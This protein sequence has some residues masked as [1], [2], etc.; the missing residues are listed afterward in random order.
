MPVGKTMGPQTKIT[1]AKGAGSMANAIHCLCGKHE[2]KQ[3]PS[4][5]SSTAETNK[6]QK[7]TTL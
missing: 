2:F 7:H 3:N 5:F 6:Q 1:K 4:S